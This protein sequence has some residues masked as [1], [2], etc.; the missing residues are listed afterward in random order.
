MVLQQTFISIQ[1][2]GNV[3]TRLLLGPPHKQ[4]FAPIYLL[5][6]LKNSVQKSLGSRWATWNINVNRDDPVTASH[7]SIRVMVVPSTVCTAPHGDDPPWLRHL[8]ID[9]AI[10]KKEAIWLNMLKPI[11]AINYHPPPNLFFFFFFCEEKPS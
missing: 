4:I 9:P 7:D 2:D 11:R 10:G 3:K 1:I 5:L 6:Q 8:I